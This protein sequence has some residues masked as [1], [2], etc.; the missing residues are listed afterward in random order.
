EPAVVVLGP[1]LRMRGQ[2]PA[3]AAALLRLNPPQEAMPPIPNSVYNVGA[4]LLA[5]EYGTPVG[6]PW[7]RIHLGGTRWLTVKADRLGA[8]DI[9]VSLAPSTPVERLDLFGRAHA[10]SARETQ[11]LGLLAGGLESR[12]MA[13][14]LALSEHAVNDHVKAILAKC[15][16]RTRHGLLS[17]ALGIT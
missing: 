11:V 4:A 3:A 7:S 9:A 14:D 10:L 5:A 6:P 2:T 16:V 1:D 12:R 13:Q 17:R 8:E 15:G